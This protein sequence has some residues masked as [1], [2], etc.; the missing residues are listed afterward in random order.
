MDAVIICGLGFIVFAM[1]LRL[2]VAFAVGMCALL[3]GFVTGTIPIMA[4]VHRMALATESWPIMAVPFSAMHTESAAC[5]A[6][7]PVAE[8]PA[9]EMTTPFAALREQMAKDNEGS[10]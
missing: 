6:L 10:T 7:A 5:R 3:Y 9:D 1:F 8:Q 4:M 2:P